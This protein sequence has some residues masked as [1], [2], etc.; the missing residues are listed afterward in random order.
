MALSKAEA[1]KKEKKGKEEATPIPMT[2]V[3]I[4]PNGDQYGE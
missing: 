2:K 1:K 4:F 3:H